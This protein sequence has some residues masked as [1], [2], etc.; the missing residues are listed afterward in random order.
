MPARTVYVKP[1]VKMIYNP[2]MTHLESYRRGKE[3]M[4]PL[5]DA[6]EARMNAMN[7]K[8]YE[9]FLKEQRKQTLKDKIIQY[10]TQAAVNWGLN[11][12]RKY[13]FGNGK[14]GKGRRR[15]YRTYRQF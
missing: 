12:I 15:R 14:R 5:T 10:G 3:F 4:K 1:N 6:Q 2:H 9:D 13:V 8:F 11:Q 7:K